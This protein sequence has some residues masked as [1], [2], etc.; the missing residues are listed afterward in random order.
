MKKK[1]KKLPDHLFAPK[2]IRIFA[3]VQL[4]IAFIVLC[5]LGI[6]PFLQNYFSTQTQILLINSITGTREGAQGELKEQIY[7]NQ[8]RFK[9]LPTEEQS[10]IIS[11]SRSLK[12]QGSYSFY[13]TAKSVLDI[14]ILKISPFVQAWLFF[15][16]TISIL[17]LLRIEGATQS[18]LI[19]PLTLVIYGLFVLLRPPQPEKPSNESSLFPTEKRVIE[20]YLKEPLSQRIMEQ[21]KQL[22]RGWQRYVVEEWAHESPSQNEEIFK[23]QVEKGEFVF[24]LARLN[25][26]KKDYV[27]NKEPIRTPPTSLLLIILGIGWSS[28]FAWGVNRKKAKLVDLSKSHVHKEESVALF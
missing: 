3:I 4:C 7:R 24:A 25:A 17:I 11:Y 10:E 5:W 1:K 21:Q 28:V 13:R 16:I 27:L 15:S 14:L 6:A 9:Q 12:Q 22:L 8:E 26:Q 20:H 23:Q 19:I 18:A 2:P